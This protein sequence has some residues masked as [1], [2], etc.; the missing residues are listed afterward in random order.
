MKKEKVVL[1]FTRITIVQKCEFGRNVVLKMTNNAKFV[2]PDVALA[3]L[4]AKTDLLEQRSII[5]L[6]GGKEATALM[7]QTEAEWDDLMRKMAKYVDR[8]A[9]GDG[10]VILNAG[11]NLAKQA[12]PSSRPE[13]SVELGD[14]SGTVALR[15]QK[16]DG[17]KSY[18]WQYCVGE[19]PSENEGDWQL[20]AAT[21]K[22]TAT[23]TGLTPLAKHWFRSSA[24]TTDGTAELVGPIAQVV[25]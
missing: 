3:D 25:I 2:N 16:V 24:V 19:T 1:D 11:F 17:A 18:I 10:A 23:I 7:H 21:S 22:V 8:I 6:S 14:K 4:N 20:G 13:F 5:A 12:T 9:D 15:R